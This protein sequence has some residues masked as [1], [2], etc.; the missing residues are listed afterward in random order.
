MQNRLTWLPFPSFQP[1]G[2]NDR[3]Y[4]VRALLKESTPQGGQS[5]GRLEDSEV[6]QGRRTSGFRKPRWV[7]RCA[8]CGGGRV[9]SENTA[10][11]SVRPYPHGSWTHG[12]G[13]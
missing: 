11:W 5:T 6:Q 9:C 8:W 7:V 1:G 12:R 4:Q 10:L 13:S 2:G 3:R